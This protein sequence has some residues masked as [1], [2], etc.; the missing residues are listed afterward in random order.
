MKLQK[1]RLMNLPERNIPNCAG[2][3]FPESMIR[4]HRHDA[5]DAGG[6]VN[7]EGD[8]GPAR[9]IVA[10]HAL[11]FAL[12]IV[13]W[14]NPYAGGPSP[15]VMPWL[16]SMLVTTL[17]WS[18]C[19]PFFPR[20]WELVLA[21]AVAASIVSLSPPLTVD[22]VALLGGCALIAAMAVVA[23]NGLRS[24]FSLETAVPPAWLAASLVSSVIA[25]CQYF[26]L[27]HHFTPLM[28]V[29]LPGE[30]F[31]NLRQRNQFATLTAMGMAALLWRRSRSIGFG[32]SSLAMGLLTTANAASASRT[33]LF[34]L[35]MLSGLCAAWKTPERQWRLG[36]CLIGGVSY[37]A[38][39]MLLPHMAQ[40]AIGLD[41][42]SVW[43]RLTGGEGCGSRTVL[44]SNVLH[45]I[46]QKPW[47][48][49]GWGELDYAHYITLYEG[50]RFCDILDNAHNLPLHFAVE[51]G[52]PI[53]LL[54]CGGFCWL[55]LR[56][57]PW[58]D[59]D[60][61][62]QLAWSV[63]AVILLHSMLEYPLWYGPFQMAFGLSLGLLWPRF[64][65]MC[66][67]PATNALDAIVLRYSWAIVAIATIGYAAW[68]YRRVSQMYLP[69]EERIA[70][71][72]V[73]PL[74]KL[75]T[76]W[77]F[78][79]QVLFAE[80]TTTPLTRANAQHTYT[81]ATE[82]LHY[83][84]EPRVIEKLIES[85]MLLGHEKQVLFQLARYR[86]AFPDAYEVW[87]RMAR[88]TSPSHVQAQPAT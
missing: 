64:G 85:A 38:A 72:R 8:G 21:L 25:L 33:G 63:L 16:V 60:S 18:L 74:S 80:L 19:N 26:G 12:L 46:A 45:L 57:R 22:G 29:S 27:A 13:P 51:L 4:L 56:A 84:P 17:L 37:L 31:A 77:L 6:S 69:P 58:R 53:A 78:R 23:S 34:H 30:A 65:Q 41:V 86:A 59:A 66:V 49:W 10:R 24:G 55:V 28:H 75:R 47:F 44:W 20:R 9:R 54:M 76:S 71:Y 42:T 81:I 3:V 14:L 15:T 68:D 39:A 40:L 48:G 73:D 32:Y 1:S 5:K 7:Y 83:S 70:A 50:P 87:V 61:E 35:I 82:L 43:G 88:P 36:L 11:V 62:R 52:I 67:R 2:S 79:N